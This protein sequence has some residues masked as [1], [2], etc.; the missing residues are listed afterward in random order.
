[1]KEGLKETIHWFK[2]TDN[3][4]KYKI[5][6]YNVYFENIIL[7][8]IVIIGLGNIGQRHLESLVLNK[9]N[10]EIY[11]YDKNNNQNKLINKFYKEKNLN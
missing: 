9:T 4:K 8:K 3:L 6:K 1:M 11:I 5:D 2:D 10:F 7:I